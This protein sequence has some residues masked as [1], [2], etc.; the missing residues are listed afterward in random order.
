[1]RRFW[2]SIVV[3]A[4]ILI[5]TGI[6]FKTFV[7]PSFE[8]EFKLIFLENDTI[9]ISDSDI[10]TYNMTNQEITITDS[11][12]KRLCDMGD[13]IYSFTGFI[14]RINSEEVY[15]GV[16]RSAIMSAIPSSPKICILFPSLL[17]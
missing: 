7:E 4:S 10:I 6:L 3:I 12:S 11:A 13:E 17:F 8:E 14:I 16:F 5:L 15:Q 1:M 9:L 2:I